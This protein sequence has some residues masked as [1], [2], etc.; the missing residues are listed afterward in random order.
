MYRYCVR[1]IS[2][3]NNVIVPFF[4][5]YPLKTKKRRDFEY[6]CI[7]MKLINNKRHLDLSGIEEI[8][9]VAMKMN[10][11]I[12]PKFLESSQTIRQTLNEDR[13]PCLEKI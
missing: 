1:S 2:D 5:K 9:H 11:K 10:R 8:A 7:Q 13:L 3:L 12:Q 4:Q 6:F